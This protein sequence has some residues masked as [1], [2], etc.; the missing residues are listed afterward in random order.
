MIFALRACDSVTVYGLSDYEYCKR[1]RNDPDIPY[2]YFDPTLYSE[3]GLFNKS[4]SHPKES[5]R[6]LTEKYIFSRWR[7]T[8]NL[9]FRYP[10][11]DDV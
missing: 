3:C 5:H 11:W 9:S 10:S 8:H 6:F 7:D 1:H 2:H 4:E